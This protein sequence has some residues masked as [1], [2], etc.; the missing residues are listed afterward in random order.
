MNHDQCKGSGV[1]KTH[2]LLRDGH[3]LHGWSGSGANAGDH[4]RLRLG[5]R[6]GERRLYEGNSGKEAG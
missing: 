2:L 4:E 5:E 1:T 6:G 3:E